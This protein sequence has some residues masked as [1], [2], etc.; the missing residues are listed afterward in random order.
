M[1]K[2]KICAALKWRQVKH[3]ASG[4]LTFR[5]PRFGLKVNASLEKTAKGPQSLPVSEA[6]AQS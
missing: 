5:L 3:K 1:W 4:V 2:I 6:A